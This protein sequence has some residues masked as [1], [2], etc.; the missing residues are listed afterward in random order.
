[1][2]LEWDI[3]LETVLFFCQ[4]V[5]QAM[6]SEW[7][8]KKGEKKHL[9]MTSFVLLIKRCF[10]WVSSARSYSSHVFFMK[11][12]KTKQKL[13]MQDWESNEEAKSDKK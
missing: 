5:P 7:E 2:Q 10:R 1:M 11:Q 9:D 4:K 8:L 12:S 13:M 6:N 3:I